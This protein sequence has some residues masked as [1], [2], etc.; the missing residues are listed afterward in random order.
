MWETCFL[1]FLHCLR[2]VQLMYPHFT[3][4]NRN[5]FALLQNC[6]IKLICFILIL[7]SA[8]TS[9]FH[10]FKA[11]IFVFKN[12]YRITIRDF[13]WIIMFVPEINFSCWQIYKRSGVWNTVMQTRLVAVWNPF[14][15]VWNG[16]QM[17]FKHKHPWNALS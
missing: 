4:N 5:I 8:S 12:H 16:F 7:I 15:T 9:L 6:I 13:C 2:Y 14:Q 10:D 11:T 1:R 3:S 17:R